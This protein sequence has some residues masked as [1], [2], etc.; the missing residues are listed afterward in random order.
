[1]KE[2]LRYQLRRLLQWIL[3]EDMAQIYNLT[4]LAEAQMGIIERTVHASGALAARLNTKDGRF[5]AADAQRRLNA[6]LGNGK[7]GK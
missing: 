7:D 5:Y 3:Q 4:R 1:M 6:L 2:R